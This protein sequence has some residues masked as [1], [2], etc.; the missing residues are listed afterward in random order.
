M[1]FWR[2][3]AYI[4]NRAMQCSVR[5]YFRKCLLLG[6][7]GTWQINF[8]LNLVHRV[9]LYALSWKTTN[10]FQQLVSQ[11]AR[12]L[13]FIPTNCTAQIHVTNIALRKLFRNIW[14]IFYICEHRI[15]E[16]LHVCCFY[17]SLGQGLNTINY[18]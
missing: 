18:N 13:L 15:K 11:K 6:N 8:M 7:N 3:L 4:I 2:R 5:N 14:K 10:K 12:R 9:N 16:F 17:S 1:K